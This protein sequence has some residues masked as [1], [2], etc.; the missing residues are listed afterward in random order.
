VRRSWSPA[1]VLLLLMPA[2]AAATDEADPI[3]LSALE[4]FWVD[5]IWRG[6]GDVVIVYQDIKVQCAEIEFNRTTMDLVARGGVILD[7]GPARFTADELHFN[8]GTKTG[9]FFNGL[10]FVPPHYRFRGRTI[11]KLDATHYRVEGATF[12]TCE[13]D[14]DSPPWSFRIRKAL[15]EEE[16]YGRFHSSAIK[17]QSVPVFYLPYLLWPIKRD[18][19]PGLLMPG[20]GYSDQLGTYFGL[21]VYFPVGRSYDTTLQLDYYSKG[22][23]GIGSEWRWA[24]KAS[25]QGQIFMY[26]IWDKVAEKWQW[27]FDGIH[28]DD[29]FFGF[30]LLAGLENL[31]DVDFFQDLDRTFEANTRRSLYSQ[32]H[33]SRSRGGFNLN[34]RADHRTT[35]FSADDIILSQLPEIELRVR[36][37]RIGTTSFYWDLI[38]SASY[39]YMDRGAN[40]PKGDYARL[41]AL[42]TLSYTLPSP[43]WLSVTPRAGGRV[44]YYTS[45]YSEDRSQLIEEPISRTYLAGG[46]DVVG[47]SFS[48]IFNR[49][50]GPFAKFKHLFEPRIEYA[51]LG[52]TEDTSQIPIFDEVDSTPFTNRARLVL[53]NRLLARSKGGVS[54]R[55]LGALDLFQEYSFSDPL[56]RGTDES[57]QWGPVGMLLRMTPTAGTGFDAQARYDVLHK[58]LQTMSLAA[59]LTRPQ[60]SLRLTWYQSFLP[61]TGERTSSQIRSMISFRKPDFPLSAGVQLA[62]DIERSEIQQQQY[63]VNWQGSCWAIAAEY[64]DLRLGTFPTRDWRI[65]IDLKGVGRLPEIKGTLSPLGGQ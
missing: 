6:V 60:G 10:G 54:A 28:T 26:T 18:R 37:K 56:I 2:A 5:D 58:H 19:S 47:P 52:G 50:L 65:I 44:T 32:I 39:L 40:Q 15:I 45:R 63:R 62:F 25:A 64:R 38:S 49:P 20:F 17:V 48:K 8:L 57:S 11:E 29:D 3:N 14:D 1:L 41:D 59:V 61:R 16:G 23:Y 34:L 21:P 30:R 53:G 27:K 35:F 22:L 46:L 31:S 13:S 4:Q 43:P 33:L 55:E 36:S 24:P 7:Q 12:T 42:P 51:V 9:I